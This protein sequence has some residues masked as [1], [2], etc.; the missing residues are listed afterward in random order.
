MSFWRRQALELGVGLA[1]LP[2]A[3]IAGAL[4]FGTLYR[5]VDFTTNRAAFF[6]VAFPFLICWMLLNRLVIK[7][8]E[9]R[10][11]SKGQNVS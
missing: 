11:E 6:L 8:I 1:S 7:R 10:R 4:V 2:I 5:F 9:R 3:A